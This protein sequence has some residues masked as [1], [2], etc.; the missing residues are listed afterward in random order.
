MEDGRAPVR[1][2]ARTWHLVV[3]EGPFPI[4]TPNAEDHCPAHST[5]IG[6]LDVP[7]QSVGRGQMANGKNVFVGMGFEHCGTA[8]PE[9]G[10]GGRGARWTGSGEGRGAGVS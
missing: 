8:G 7:V 10:R 9:A 1:H 3:L 6:F 2:P 5:A 4:R